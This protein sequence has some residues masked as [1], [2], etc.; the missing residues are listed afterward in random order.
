MLKQPPAVSIARFGGE[1]PDA[2]AITLRA[3]PKKSGRPATGRDPIM[4]LRMPP[5]LR[6]DLENWA[7]RQPDN[8]SLSEALRQLLEWALKMKDRC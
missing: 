2:N 5:A 1:P 7:K 8:P 4:A 3:D 6:S